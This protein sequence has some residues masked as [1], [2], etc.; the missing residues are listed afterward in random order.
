MKSVSHLGRWAELHYESL[1]KNRPDLLRQYSPK[2]LEKYLKDLDDQAEERYNVIVSQLHREKKPPEDF[3]ELA[4]YHQRNHRIAREFVLNDLVLVP[5][6]ET[7]KAMRH[8]YLDEY[9]PETTP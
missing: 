1:K 5:D 3:L 8:G 7:E 4:Q 6:L 2:E 9:P